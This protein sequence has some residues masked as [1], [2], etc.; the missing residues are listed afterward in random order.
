[1]G[2][3]GGGGGGMGLRLCL[4]DCFSSSTV[5]QDSLCLGGAGGSTLLAAAPLFLLGD[6]RV[7][8][9]VQLLLLLGIFQFKVVATDA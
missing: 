6:L 5:R 3:V 1:M 4:S 7:H 9:W 2:G 8:Q